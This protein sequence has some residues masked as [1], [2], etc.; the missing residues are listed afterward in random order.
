MERRAA[1]IQKHKILILLCLLVF[2]GC[3]TPPPVKQALADM[4]AGY[5]ENLNLMQ[6]YRKL[7]ENIQERHRYWYRYTQQRLLLDL[8]LRSMTQ[9]YWRGKKGYVDDTADL[10]GQDLLKVV[11]DL[12]L[13]GLEEQRGTAETVKFEAGKTGN[14]ASKIVERLPEVVNRVTEKVEKDYQ[15]RKNERKGTGN[16][17]PYDS[18]L[19]NV[20]ALR[21]INATIKR[22]LDIDVTISPE[23]LS[24]I[25][26]SI[27]Q[28]QQ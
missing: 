7:T 14:S 21:Q 28:L 8:A 25:A 12:R 6:Q 26:K 9:D 16:M 1:L 13:A 19:T 5:A 18:Y 23:D 20:S 4:D 3:A 15:K 22:Y 17:G 2:I 10:L 11:N 24:E 27:R